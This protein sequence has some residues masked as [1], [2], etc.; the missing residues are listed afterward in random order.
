MA[1]SRPTVTVPASETFPR[2]REFTLKSIE[3]DTTLAEPHIALGLLNFLQDHDFAG[4]DR[5]SQLALAANPNSADAHRLN[6]L[7]LQYLGRFD[8]ALVET[9]RALE[10]EPLSTAAN[11]SYS[12][13]LFYSGRIEE[14]EAQLKKAIELTPDLWFSHYYLYNLY[15]FKGNY[16]PA[17]E[18][19]AKSKD[20][21]D[22][23]EAAKLIRE[24]F[25]KG[26]WQGF[27]RA[28]TA[29]AQTKINPYTLA[30]L[31]AELGNKDQAFAALNEA[32]NKSDQSIGFVKVD[33][34]MKPLHDDPRFAALLKRV[35]FPQ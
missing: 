8:E 24:S 3:L 34:F 20:L 19:L 1:I 9:K 15:R 21:R 18:E 16:A 25:A 12:L 26:G 31:Y 5:E 4:W 13:S 30:G 22:E 32:V 27:L 17:V 28:A 29:D 6:G 33:P 23:T 11:I 7:R 10:L 14:S 35:G 2:A